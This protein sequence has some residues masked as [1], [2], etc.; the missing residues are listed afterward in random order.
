MFVLQINLKI[1]ELNR[2]IRLD[3]Q[4]DDSLGVQKI[5]DPFSSA[6]YYSYAPEKCSNDSTPIGVLPSVSVSI[7][8]SYFFL[9]VKTTLPM[10]SC[11]FQKHFFLNIFKNFNE[12]SFSEFGN[13]CAFLKVGWF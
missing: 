7:Y 4:T 12:N 6:P 10:E 13:F 11:C 5:C 8:S 9:A 1:A 3:E 2:F